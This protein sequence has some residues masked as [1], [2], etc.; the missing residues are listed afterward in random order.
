MQAEMSAQ[1]VDSLLAQSVQEVLESM[2][3]TMVDA[4]ADEPA[5]YP[6]PRI[7]VDLEFHG[8]R[9]GAFWL[10]FPSQTAEEVGAA[11]AG[12]ETPDAQRTAEVLQELANIMCGA[13]LSRIAGD[14]LF[15][16]GSPVATLISERRS[17]P[18]LRHAHRVDFQIGPE[19]V[20]A[21]IVFRTGT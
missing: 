6:V 19:V 9:D 14:S 21:A 5:E 16:L 10:S 12:A 18:Q 1:D 13:T 15:D 3:F 2:C 8:A 4:P 7:E 11:F 20:S 17:G